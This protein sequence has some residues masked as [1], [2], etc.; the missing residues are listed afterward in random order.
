M[1]VYINVQRRLRNGKATR[2]TVVLW[3]YL[4]REVAEDFGGKTYPQFFARNV[5]NKIQFTLFL[6]RSGVEA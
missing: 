6:D 3:Q 2:F 5:K 1:G 4:V